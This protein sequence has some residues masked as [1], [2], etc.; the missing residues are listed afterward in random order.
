[1]EKNTIIMKEIIS[2]HETTTIF[3]NYAAISE[4]NYLALF[5]VLLQ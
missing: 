3:E 5:Y 4:R 2:Y 1:M